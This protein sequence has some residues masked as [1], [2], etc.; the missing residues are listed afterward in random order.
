MSYRFDRRSKNQFIEDIYISHRMELKLMKQYVAWLNKTKNL[1]DDKIYSFVDNGI[2]NAGKFLE[3][4][5]VD[6]RAD[7]I[8]KRFGQTDRKIDIKFCREEKDYFHF[9]THQVK[10]Y[11]E[12]DTCIVNYMAVNTKNNRFTI[13][14][15]KDLQLLLD[16]KSKHTIFWEKE[17]LRI[18]C[19]D[20]KWNQVNF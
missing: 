19:K 17:C 10:K 9:K 15:P 13:F 4:G 20:C 1:K 3:D 6:A 14:R 11:I 7:F 16:D 8:L 2:D 18:Y 12:T 5:E